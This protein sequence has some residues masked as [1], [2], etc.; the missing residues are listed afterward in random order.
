MK[1]VWKK[2]RRKDVK[3]R[4]KSKRKKKVQDQNYDLPFFSNFNYSLVYHVDVSECH[5]GVS[6]LRLSG[7]GVCAMA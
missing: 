1:D 7:V 2:E 3:K 6:E 4:R 5:V